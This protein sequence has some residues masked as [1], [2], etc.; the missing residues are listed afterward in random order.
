MLHLCIEKYLITFYLCSDNFKFETKKI[1]Y[2]LFLLK[3]KPH[4]NVIYFKIPLES[5]S[6]DTG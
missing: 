2:Y 5:A 1:N 3:L 4:L 6:R